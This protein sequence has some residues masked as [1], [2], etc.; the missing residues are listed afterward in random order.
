[1]VDVEKIVEIALKDKVQLLIFWLDNCPYSVRARDYGR[2]LAKKYKMKVRTVKVGRISD[3][4][5]PYDET[6]RLINKVLKTKQT[7][8]TWP[9]VLYRDGNRFKRIKGGCEGLLNKNFG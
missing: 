1:M 6:G 4:E 7:K 9:Q 3:L 8:I 5:R 2:S